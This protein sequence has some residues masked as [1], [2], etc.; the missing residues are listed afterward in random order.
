MRKTPTTPTTIVEW[1]KNKIS[2]STKTTPRTKECNHLPARQP[3][4]VMAEKEERETDDRDD[5]GETEARNLKFE[6]GADNPA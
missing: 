2:I 1:A 6:I 4:E 5:A 3:G